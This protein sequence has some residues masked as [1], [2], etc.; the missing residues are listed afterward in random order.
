[1]N[2]DNRVAMENDKARVDARV[3]VTGAAKFTADVQPKGMIYAA[4][5]RFP[6]GSGEL[7]EADIDAAK[8]VPGVIE[9]EVTVPRKAG[10][11]GA[12]IGYVCGNTRR[13]VQDGLAALKPKYRKGEARSH[14]ADFSEGPAKPSADDQARLDAIFAKGAAVVEATYSTQVQTHSALETHGGVVDHR[15][16]SAEVWGSTQ[17]TFAYL[18]GIAGACELDASKVVVHNEFVGGGF[19]AKFGPDAEGTLAAKLSKKHQLPCRV[20]LNRYEEHLDSGNRPGSIQ[21][22]KIAAAKDGKLLGGSIHVEGVVGYRKGGGE[23]TNPALYEFGDVVSSSSEILLTAGRPRAFRAPGWPQGV[24][25]VESMMDELAAKLGMDP[26]AFRLLNEKSAR[27]RKQLEEGAEIFGWNRR[28]PDGTWPGVVKHG[29]GVA[30]AEWPTWPTKAGADIDVFRSGKVEV[31]AGV[32]D[33]GTGTTTVVA[34]VAAFELGIPREMIVPRVGNSTF[35]E[36][37]GS[38][39]SQVTRSIAPAIMDAATQI[40]EQLTELV[41]EKWGGAKASYDKGVFTEKGGSRTL[42]WE[43]ACSLMSGQKLSARGR[44][45]QEFIREGNSDGVQFFEVAVDTETGVVRVVKVVAI[46]SVG[47][48]VNRLMLENQICGGVTQGISYALFEDRW[49]DGPTGGMVNPNLEFYKIAGAKDIPEIIPIIDATA[50]DTGVRPVGE[51]CTI[52]CA[53]AIANAVANAIGA[54]VRSIPIT[55]QRVL[56]ALATKGARS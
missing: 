55:P 38:G 44:I 20:M 50:D 23:A 5:L 32:Q 28:K 22:M 54:R 25:A 26:V 9:V 14:A 48:A 35:P 18:D 10:Y 3:K 53:G 8:K 1:M 12:N 49:L 19:G 43:D 39:G 15:G 42:K 52:P 37:P 4:F 29:F 27:R 47:R 45:K 16:E 7:I 30:G 6:Y 51:P 31:R 33:I 36:G 17:G 41:E 21:H 24:F 34:D 2:P 46:Q 56:E 13:A 11:V 40:R